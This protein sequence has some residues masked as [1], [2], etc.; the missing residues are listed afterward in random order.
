VTDSPVSAWFRTLTRTG[1]GVTSPALRDP[2]VS[3]LAGTVTLSGASSSATVT[4]EAAAWGSPDGIPE[5]AWYSVPGATVTLAGSGAG[6][7]GSSGAGLPP[8]PVTVPAARYLRARVSGGGASAVAS[9][10]LTA[11]DY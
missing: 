3:T 5:G 2:G 1:P 10:V 8:V 4:L 9:L 11:D 7:L 6:V